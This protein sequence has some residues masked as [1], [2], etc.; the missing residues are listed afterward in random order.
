MNRHF[1][2]RATEARP[3]TGS[4]RGEPAEPRR[5]RRINFEFRNSNFAIVSLLSL[6]LCG[7]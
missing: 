4:G 7:K 6:R 1:G 2:Q 3:S 5:T